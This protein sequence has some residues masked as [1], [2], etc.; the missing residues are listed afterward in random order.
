MHEVNGH[1]LDRSKAAV[2]SADQL[3]DV[4]PQVLILLDILT[5]GHGDLNE[6]DFANPFRVLVK[7][8]LHRM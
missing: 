4:A 3:V 5:R 6:N 2:D 7:E 1:E 8:N